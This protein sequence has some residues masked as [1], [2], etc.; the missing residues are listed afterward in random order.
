MHCWRYL[1]SKVFWVIVI[2]PALWPDQEPRP[3]PPGD[4]E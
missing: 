3:W 1:F 2:P 4:L